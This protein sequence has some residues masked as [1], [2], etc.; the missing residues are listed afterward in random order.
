MLA[1]VVQSVLGVGSATCFEFCFQMWLLSGTT[2]E[3]KV[4]QLSTQLILLQR[5]GGI[6]TK[7]HFQA[8]VHER[9]TMFAK[10]PGKHGRPS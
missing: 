7:D 10:R 8:V 2:A 9:T 4:H 1:A 5:C 6:T 3:T